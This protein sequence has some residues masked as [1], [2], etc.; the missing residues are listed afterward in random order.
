MKVEDKQSETLFSEIGTGEVFKIL[1]KVMIKTDYTC[2]KM[3][4]CVDLETGKW[5][6][7]AA[8][9]AV[10]PVKAEVVVE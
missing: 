4:W 8:E 3:V 7:I 2:N 10:E 5:K 9:Q 6:A 1:N